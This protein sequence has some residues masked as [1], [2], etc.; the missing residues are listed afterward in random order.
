[1]NEIELRPTPSDDGDCTLVHVL[2]DG[3]DLLEWVK[4]VELPQATADRQPDL[5]GSYR[6][7]TPAQW[8]SLPEEY[9]HERG[10][11]FGCICGEVECWPLR[12]RIA[13]REDTVVWSDFEQPHRRRWTY[14]A[15]GPFTFSRA[16]YEQAF[17]RGFAGG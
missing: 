7:L 17:A 2:I 10:A 15:L 14:D 9:G 11:V 1:V 5:A 13:W 12:H 8:R 16:Q 4:E 6:P 3:R